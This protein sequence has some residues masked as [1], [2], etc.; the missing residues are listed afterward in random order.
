MEYL[1]HFIKHSSDYQHVADFQRLCG[2]EIVEVDKFVENKSKENG[3]EQSHC[4]IGSQSQL[5]SHNGASHRTN[6]KHITNGY[7]NAISNYDGSESKLAFKI[8]NKPLNMLFE[9]GAGLGSEVFYITFFPFMIW[10]VDARLTRQICLIW[11][12]L[13][14]VGQFLKDFIQWPRPGPPAVRLEGKRFEMEYGMPSTHTI[15][16]TCIPF[17]LLVLTSK[18]YEYP[19]ALGLLLAVSWTTLVACSRVYMGMHTALDCIVGVTI[20]AVALPWMLPVVEYVEYFEVTS[21]FG[22]FASFLVPVLACVYYPKPKVWSIT[23][24]DTSN[25][26]SLASGVMVATW[27]SYQLGWMT[28]TPHS[29]ERQHLP[30]ITVEWIKLSLVRTVFGVV[31]LAGSR[32]ITKPFILK[33]VCTLA[34]VDT[35]DITKQRQ[36]GLEVPVRW[37]SVGGLAV[38]AAFFAPICFSYLG[39]NREGYYSEIGL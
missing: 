19:F 17:T 2:V 14:F 32:I 33:L 24:G 4:Q 11:Y 28:E 23:R 1:K 6:G 25:I 18:Y 27:F 29:L 39:I 20:T 5:Y 15:V 8:H 38:L 35:K 37:L 36:L 22:P 3:S 34:D 21:P 10:N 30:A 7:K 26:V 12:P 16:A 9:F 13:M 31:A